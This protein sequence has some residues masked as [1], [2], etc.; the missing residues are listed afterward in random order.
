MA[1]STVVIPR[2]TSVPRKRLPMRKIEEVLR[3][4]A[5]GM[6]PR[7]IAASIGAGKSTV[8]EYL[9]RAGAAGVSGPLPDGLDEA[10]VEAKLFPEPSA[11]LAARRPVPDWAS[12]PR[13]AEERAPRDAAPAVARVPRGQPRGLGLQP[14]LCPLPGL[15][16]RPGCRDA[17]VVHGRGA[18]VRRL[19]GRHGELRRP[20]HR[21]DRVR[22][23]VRGGAGDE[24]DAL[25]R[26]YEGPGPRLLDQRPRPRLG[27]LPRGR[28]PH[29]PRQPEVGGDQGV[30]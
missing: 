29:R 2:R 12:D 13:R 14:V 19:L 16:G 4:K 28:H 23:G 15:A 17:P 21:R 27:G 1:T 22:P 3:L 26:G 10:T 8:Y 30:L 6:S 24:R 7:T 20:G 11:E 25:R 9:S 18:H 5:A